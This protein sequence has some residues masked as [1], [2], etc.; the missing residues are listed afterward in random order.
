MEL[1]LRC[2]VAKGMLDSEYAIAFDVAGGT[3]SAFVAQSKVRLHGS[4]ASS[5]EVPGSVVVEL[6]DENDSEGLVQ[7]PAQLINGSDVI[8]VPKAMLYTHDPLER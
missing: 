7:L 4:L 2:R 1:L 8:K 3:A 5:T 6:L